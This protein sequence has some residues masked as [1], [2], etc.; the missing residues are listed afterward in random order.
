MSDLMTTA[1]SS[2]QCTHVRVH[3]SLTLLTLHPGN[4]T[5]LTLVEHELAGIVPNATIL[6]I[7]VTATTTIGQPLP[8]IDLKKVALGCDGIIRLDQHKRTIYDYIQSRMAFIAPNVS[9]LVRV[10]I[11]MCAHAHRFV[12]GCVYFCIDCLHEYV[13]RMCICMCAR[14]CLHA[15]SFNLRCIC[16]CD[17]L[18]IRVLVHTCMHIGRI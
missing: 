1:I 14:F 2:V 4:E 17:H 7:S 12:S 5:D 6:T 8:D 18:H 9:T 11:C 3:M 16:T 15:H 10:C 13:W